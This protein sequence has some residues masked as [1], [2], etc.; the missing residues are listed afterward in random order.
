MELFINFK[1]KVLEAEKLQLDTVPSF[2]KE[3]S[4]YEKQ[5]AKP[6][7]NENSVTET[8][9]K[10]AYERMKFEVSAAHILVKVDEDAAPADTL[11]AYNKIL[12]I[13]KKSNRRSFF[14]RN[15]Y[16]AF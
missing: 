15:G 4:G 6:Y 16:K 7:L 9:V 1:L 3:L 2:Q 8:L 14:W 10:E 5:L 13:R 11:A 12:E